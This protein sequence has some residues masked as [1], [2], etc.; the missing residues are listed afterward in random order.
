LIYNR[1]IAGTLA[2]D[3]ETMRDH[4]HQTEQDTIDVVTFLKKQDVNKDNEVNND[5]S[6]I[7]K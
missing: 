3:N 7:D 6:F 4:M 5:F 1:D 2:N